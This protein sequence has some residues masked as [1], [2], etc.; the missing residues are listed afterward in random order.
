[1]NESL[2][3]RLGKQTRGPF[4][5]SQLQRMAKLGHFGRL[6]EVSKD[7]L[8]WRSAAS[9]ID[10]W[11]AVATSTT[12]PTE[13]T[14]TKNE[15]APLA[16]PSF[17]SG[18]PSW[19]Y[20]V[21]GTQIGPKTIDEVR[22]A[23]ANKS[24]KSNALVWREGLADWTAADRF[25]DFAMVNDAGVRRGPLWLALGFLV[26]SSL[27]FAAAAW[28]KGWFNGRLEPKPIVIVPEV[29]QGPLKPVVAAA[30]VPP[31]PP[32]LTVV[33]PDGRPAALVEL[34]DEASPAQI[35]RAYRSRVY[36]LFIQVNPWDLTLLGQKVP[37]KGGNGT[38]SGI[39]L[40]HDGRTSLIATNRHVVC[41]D[42]RN[43]VGEVLKGLNLERDYYKN[44]V[45]EGGRRVKVKQPDWLEPRNAF[46]AA[47]HRERDIAFVLFQEDGVPPFATA[48]VN[49]SK[50]EQG[51]R[52]VAL[53]NPLGLEFFTTDGLITSIQGQGGYLWTNCSLSSGNSGGPLLLSRRGRLV[54]LNTMA[55]GID[56]AVAQN[57]NAAEP[58]DEPVRT[59][60]DLRNDAW[61]WNPTLKDKTAALAKMVPIVDQ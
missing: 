20:L 13:P 50:C 27:A 15:V 59:L 2:Y 35:T 57:L 42:A 23:I 12:A 39:A 30:D 3:I 4:D 11:Q 46:I 5:Q 53:G 36:H 19:Y 37:I 45:F 44:H 33:A 47:V 52:A 60:A 41:P 26:C 22:T 40:A 8:Q 31:A 10:G 29:P 16:D 48:I 28:H 1:M 34:P 32:K 61:Y 56:G 21:A 24:I 38:G 9:V 49:H 25:P 54:G 51:E 18:S 55:I 6:H 7:R 43:M 14:A 58:M 17:M